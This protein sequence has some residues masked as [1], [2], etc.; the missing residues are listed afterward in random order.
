MSKTDQMA[1]IANNVLDMYQLKQK[2]KYNYDE[3]ERHAIFSI[4]RKISRYRSIEIPE[5]S[6]RINEKNVSKSF[7]SSLEILDNDYIYDFFMK[8]LDRM[9]IARKKSIAPDEAILEYT[10]KQKGV[11]TEFSMHLPITPLTVINQIGFAH[12]MGHIPEIDKERES[13]YEY[14]EVLP[15][16]FE[17]LASLE[18]YSPN[19]AK[20]NYIKDRLSNLLN[21]AYNIQKIYRRCNSKKKVEKLYFNQLYAENYRFLE[22]MDYTLQL[23]DLF[24][25]EK[26]SVTDELEKVIK[27]KS[28]I[29]VASDLSIDPTGCRRLMREYKEK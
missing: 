22:S 3:N 20:D 25:Q 14:V 17:Y 8:H 18:S 11:Q 7:I 4:A 29:K 2:Y 21:E 1:F 15:F 5:A 10:H 23:I 19:T 28:L 12:E 6:N 13:F 16:F 24:E 26:E 9:E 27:G